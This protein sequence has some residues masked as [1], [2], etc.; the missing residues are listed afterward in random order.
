MCSGTSLREELASDEAQYHAYYSRHV[1]LLTGGGA[2]R[3]PACQQRTTTQ[4]DT[5][6]HGT[7]Q[8]VSPHLAKALALEVAVQPRQDEPLV[9]VVGSL[10]AELQQICDQMRLE[11]GQAQSFH[12]ERGEERCAPRLADYACF[13]TS[14]EQQWHEQ[15]PPPPHPPIN[16]HPPTRT[17]TSVCRHTHLGRTEPRPRQ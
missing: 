6:R 9:L 10:G 1:E 7:T 17:T 2:S 13:G 11:A 4:H 16:T 15:G 3:L 8:P 12:A 5:A 14:A